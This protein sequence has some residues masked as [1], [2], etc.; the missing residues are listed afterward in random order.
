VNKNLLRLL[1]LTSM[2]AAVV[3]TTTATASA[4]EL[5][6]Y[7]TDA[8]DSSFAGQQATWCSYDGETVFNVV[9]IEHAGDLLMV[10]NADSEQMVGDGRNAVLG[11]GGIALSTWSSVPVSDRYSVGSVD[12]EERLG[13]KVAVVTVDEGAEVRARIW[14]DDDTGAVLGSE[15]YDGS[16]NLFRLSWMLDFDPYP[17]KIYTVMG[18]AG[19]T[20]DVV[21]SA[22]AGSL[23]ATIAGYERVDT[24]D[25]PDDSLHAFYADGLFSFSL[26]VIDGEVDVSSF[27]NADAMRVAGNEYR[28][29]LTSS[30]LWLQWSTGGSTYVLVGD[31]PPDHLR[32]VLT[33]LPQPS[34]RNLLV[35]LWRGLFG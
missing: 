18:E 9:S 15:V 22:D 21:A 27:R 23:P 13:R 5:E 3:A 32:E 20:Y 12:I 29:L 16:G 14:F 35:R 28:W 4:G 8:A 25:G 34:R 7:L 6:D 10:E 11:G 31:L 19:S 30:D 26:F 24:Y 17:R 33:E 2:V 1:L